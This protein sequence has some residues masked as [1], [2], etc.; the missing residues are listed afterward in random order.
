MVFSLKL[1]ADNHGEHSAH[2][3]NQFLYF[4]VFAVPPWLNKF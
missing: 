1:S 2:G 4:A 3:E